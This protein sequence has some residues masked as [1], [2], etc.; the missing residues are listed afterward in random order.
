MKIST[1][2]KVTFRL[3]ERA[4]THRKSGKDWALSI[5]IYDGESW[6]MKTW[7]KKPVQKTIDDTKEI[8]M[9]LKFITCTY[10]CRSLI[11]PRVN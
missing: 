3:Y 2:N 9:R 1:G 4:N 5:Q 11:Y 8:I 7:E 10:N 6:V